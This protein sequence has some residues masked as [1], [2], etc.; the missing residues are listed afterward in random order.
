MG[1]SRSPHLRERAAG[2]KRHGFVIISLAILIALLYGNSLHNSWHFD[3]YKNIVNNSNVHLSDLSWGGIEKSFEGIP[4]ESIHRPLSYFTFALNY[5]AGRLDVFGYHLVNICIHYLTAIS[6]FFLLHGIL[7]LPRLRSD[8]GERA[9]AIAFLSAVLWAVHPIQVTAVTYIVQ[10]MT[11]LC[12]FFYV[13]AMFLYIRA[14]TAGSWGKALLYGG[15][16]LLAAICSLAAKENA[17]MLP[18]AIFLLDLLL[19]QGISPESLNR[20][21]IFVILPFLL[22]LIIL[23]FFTNLPGL[24]GG[25]S[26]RPFTLEERVMTEPRIVLFYVSLLLYPATSRLTLLHDV[27]LSTSLLHPWTTGPAIAAVLGGIILAVWLARRKPLVSFCLFFFFLNHIVE[28]TVLPLELIYEHRNYLP[29]LFLFT[30]VAMGAVYIFQ[31]FAEKAAVQAGGGIALAVAL[32]LMGT[33]VSARNHVF[34]DEISLWSENVE[35]SPRLQRPHHNLGVAYLAAGRLAEGRDQL[36][37]ALQARDVSGLHNKS[38]SWFYLGQYYRL[39]GADDEAIKH[40]RQALHVAPYNPEPYQAMAEIMMKR[41][42]LV[43]AEAHIGKA[44]TLKPREGAYHLTYAEIMLRKRW[45]DA[46]IA[47]AKRAIEGRGDQKR[48]YEL[49]AAAYAEKKD[50][51]S[52]AYYGKWAQE[53]CP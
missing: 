16:C 6:L 4:G 33:T 50:V 51:M 12:A 30:P 9:S 37:K 46:A 48:A 28:S 41:N 10:R 53:R 2:A 40:F 29:S 3:D 21:F 25:Y 26:Q 5:Y 42:D 18:L 31:R 44:L 1:V 34:L 23:F 20:N 49:L 13:T 32:I 39:A 45:P 27:E 7:N 8:Y 22:V 19:I 47:E 35:K 52:A 24:I 36:I 15:L 11:S 38:H 14:R 43:S 17:V